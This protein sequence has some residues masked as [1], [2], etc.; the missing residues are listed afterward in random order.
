VEIYISLLLDLIHTR[1]LEVFVHPPAPVLDETRP[2]VRQFVAQLRRRCL[3]VRAGSGAG[4]GVLPGGAQAAAKKLHFL[5]FFDELLGEGGQGL[6]AGLSL[7]GT[8]MA[9]AYLAHLQ[10][11]LDSCAT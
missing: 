5:D 1:R 2:V 10:A 7:D 4:K 8:H 11:A 3:D 6:K 9:P